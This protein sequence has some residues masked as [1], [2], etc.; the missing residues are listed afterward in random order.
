MLRAPVASR[1]RVARLAGVHVLGAAA[2]ESGCSVPSSDDRHL[3]AAQR[4]D[5]SRT[6][7]AYQL[8]AGLHE[9]V[10]RHA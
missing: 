9:L 4:L 10:V 2:D 5:P 8:E 6:K 1:A 7:V 3:L